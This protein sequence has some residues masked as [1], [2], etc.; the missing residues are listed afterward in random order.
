MLKKKERSLT[1]IILW[2]LFSFGLT[3]F[4]Y[5]KDNVWIALLGSTLGTFWAYTLI[6]NLRL[7]TSKK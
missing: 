5:T 3:Y 7:Q 4:E 2:I 6:Q 1:P